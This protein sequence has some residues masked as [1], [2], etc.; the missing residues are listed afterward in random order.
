MELTITLDND[1]GHLCYH[2]PITGDYGSIGARGSNFTM[3]L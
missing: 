1:I 3:Y 2:F